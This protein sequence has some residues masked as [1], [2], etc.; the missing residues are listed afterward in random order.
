[1]NIL[2]GQV[3]EDPIRVTKTFGQTASLT[4]H[5]KE[6]TSVEDPTFIIE[7]PSQI[8]FNYVKVAEWNRSYFV[9]EITALPGGRFAVA[10]HV[11]VLSSFAT[12]IQNCR[13]IIDK[14]QGTAMTSPYID[15]GS[16]V[17]QCDQVIQ[18]YNFPNGFNTHTTILITAGGD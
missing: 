6:G 13:A 1:M 5:I 8:N 2:L 17:V 12:G 15:D 18:S 9:R 16:Y 10:C 3:T 14:Q 11:D 7:T 4:A